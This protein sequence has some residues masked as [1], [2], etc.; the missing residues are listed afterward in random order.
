MDRC[1][2]PDQV[3]PCR[4]ELLERGLDIVEPDVG[5]EAVDGCVNAGR[6]WSVHVA[7]R[8]HEAR[9]HAQ[10]SDT[11]RVGRFRRIAANPRI[12]VTPKIELLRFT[13]AFDGEGRM[14]AQQSVAKCREIPL[15]LPA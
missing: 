4:Y 1:T 7:I 13:Q 10:V 3:W 8:W 6:P 15:V 12:V 5:E 14:L 2:M 11:A 9:Q